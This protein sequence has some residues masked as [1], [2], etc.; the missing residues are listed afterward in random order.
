M[1]KNDMSVIRV[2]QVI[3]K[4]ADGG[5]EAVV[6]NYYRHTDTDHIQFDYYI[7]S[8][9]EKPPSQEMIDRGARYFIVPPSR[10]PL[11]RIQALTRLFR[12]KSYVIV[13]AH[14]NTL[15]APV[16]YAA[17]RAGV[18]VRISHNHSTGNASEWKRAVA[19]RLL[20]ATGS[21]FATSRMAC[22]EAAGRWFFGDRLFE[23]GSVCVLP[24]AI[25]V[26]RYRFDPVSRQ[27]LRRELGVNDRLMV[28]HAGRFMPQKNHAFVLRIFKA[29]LE[30]K[31]DAA[32]CLVGDGDLRDQIKAQAE[33]MGIAGSVY[34]LGSRSDLAALYSAMDCFLLPSLYEGLPLVGVEAQAAGLPCF[35]SKDVSR[36][37][38]LSDEAMFI[39]L[40]ESPEKW[41]EAILRNAPLPQEKRT[42]GECR[43]RGT[44]FDLD[45]SGK[46]LEDFYRAQ[47]QL[48]G[49]QSPLNF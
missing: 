49:A 21:W 25:D 13:H 39:S 4:L 20:L 22:G 3:G 15:N 14:M 7:D 1:K 32:L 18:P 45:V 16:L 24:N 37:V 41:V 28:G 31:P 48:T 2:A 47:C 6:N 26:S 43:V 34:F 5:V 30:R 29:L 44:V 8:D 36:E 33:Q 12:S 11:R 38:A 9:S 35:F 10:H 40:N 27:R 46:A 17:W 23:S 19:K 42:E